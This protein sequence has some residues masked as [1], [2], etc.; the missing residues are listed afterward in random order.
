MD[1]RDCVPYFCQYWQVE[2]RGYL[3]FNLC[4]GLFSDMSSCKRLR[5][6]FGSAVRTSAVLCLMAAWSIA[7]VVTGEFRSQYGEEPFATVTQRI[8][9][10]PWEQVGFHKGNIMHF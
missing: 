5:L 7:C 1:G 4:S 10:V 6:V 8:P 3:G 9:K 2:C